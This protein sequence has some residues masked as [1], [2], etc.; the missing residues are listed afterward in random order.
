[1]TDHVIVVPAVHVGNTLGFVNSLDPEIAKQR[2]IVVDNTTS[3]NIY[4]ALRQ[5]VL[6]AIDTCGDNR[7]VAS[8]WNIG[9]GFART[10]RAQFLTI[11]S[12]SLRFRDGGRA[13]CK[14]A[15]IAVENQQWRYGFESLNGWRCFTLGRFAWG[16]VGL[17]D[18]GFHPAYFEDNDYIWRMRVA[19]ILEYNPHL[20]DRSTRKIPWVGALE[21]DV[22]TDAHAIKNCGIR[23]DF[24]ELEQRYIRKWGGKPGN[25]IWATPWNGDKPEYES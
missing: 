22:V 15:D 16:T 20:G 2:L 14:T 21:A 18:E 24:V 12:T 7:G 8:S 23:I 3:G 6:Q 1:M 4:T 19:G 13:L 25:E 10:L 9:L 17:F 5:D 11:C